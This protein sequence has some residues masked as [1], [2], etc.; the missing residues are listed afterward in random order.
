M[1]LKPVS[2]ASVAITA[3]GPRRSARRWADD[4][5]AGR[6][7]REDAFLRG[8]AG[9]HLD[10]FHVADRL[11]MVDLLGVPARRHE[12]GRS[13]GRTSGVFPIASR[14]DSTPR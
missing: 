10:R 3:S 1:Y 12:P 13:G 6:D 4:V 5:R 14:M 7:A 11:E 8:E 9:G 2:K